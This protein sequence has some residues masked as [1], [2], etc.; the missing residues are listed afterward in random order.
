MPEPPPKTAGAHWPLDRR[1]PELRK[2]MTMEEGKEKF[3]LGKSLGSA[4]EL[5]RLLF[6]SADTA[7]AL[8]THLR[9]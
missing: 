2:I 3:R 7:L 5:Y 8:I 1:A 9:L 6:E 4:E